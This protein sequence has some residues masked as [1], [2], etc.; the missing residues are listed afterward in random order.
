MLFNRKLIIR[1][2]LLLKN[3]LQYKQVVTQKPSTLLTSVHGTRKCSEH[4][5]KKDKHYFG[6]K[7]YGLQR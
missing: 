6:Y 5:Q 3:Q 2:Y 4:H 1:P 7:S